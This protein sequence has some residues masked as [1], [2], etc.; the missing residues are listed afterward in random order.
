M[1]TATFFG[2]A[3]AAAPVPAAA[4]LPFDTSVEY[5]YQDELLAPAPAAAAA[6]AEGS[7]KDGA[8]TTA[9]HTQYAL[10]E[11]DSPVVGQPDR[12]CLFLS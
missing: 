1:C 12:Y 2:A 11:F 5:A 8:V 3:P 4:T 7:K 9:S 10:L 6:A